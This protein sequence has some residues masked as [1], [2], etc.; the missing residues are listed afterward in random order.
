[1]IYFFNG[2]VLDD[3]YSELLKL[4]TETNEMFEKAE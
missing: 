2:Q 3:G 1:M 4:P